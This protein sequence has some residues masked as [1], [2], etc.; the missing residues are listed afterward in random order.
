MQDEAY[1]QWRFRWSVL[2]LSLALLCIGFLSTVIETIHVWSEADHYKV[3]WLVAPT[4]L[5]LIFHLRSRVLPLAPQACLWGLASGILFSMVWVAA[6]WINISVLRQ[7]ALF[8]VVCSLVL[9]AVGFSVFKILLP[10]LALLLFAIPV[11]EFF[12]PQFKTLA[13]LFVQAYSKLVGLPLEVEEYFLYVGTQRY[14]VI[15]YCAGLSYILL[16]AFFGASFGVLIYQSYWRILMITCLG[17]VFAFF[18]NVIRISSIIT[19]DYLTGVANTHE[20]FQMPSLLPC[21]VVLFFIFSRLKPENSVINSGSVNKKPFSKQRSLLV[22]VGSAIIFTVFPLVLA[23]D[24][25]DQLLSE[26]PLIL[27]NELGQWQQT[28]ADPDW[29]PS[30]KSGDVREAVANFQLG[31]HNVVVYVAEPK[32]ARVKISGGAVDSSQKG[33]MKYGD[34]VSKSICNDERCHTYSQFSSALAKTKKIRH[35]Y[36]SYAIN[37]NMTDSA[38][39]FR[40]RR[41]FAG[42]FEKESKPRFIAVVLEGDT[43]LKPELLAPIFQSLMP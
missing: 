41:A 33:W 5:A 2:A 1:I 40:V 28:G 26:A 27:S 24:E 23:V 34:T 36:Y 17:G 7:L 25:S 12:L 14:V 29:H 3:G 16:G 42:M 9:T 15:D 18:A 10:C 31:D 11:W 4:I 21:F 43:L 13:I 38:L 8:G 32:S 30:F 35:V 22:V 39:E 37:G 20:Q 19:Y 6:D